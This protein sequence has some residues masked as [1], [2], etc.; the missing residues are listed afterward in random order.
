MLVESYRYLLGPCARSSPGAAEEAQPEAARGD[1]P[2][3]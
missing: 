1:R 2:L 3:L